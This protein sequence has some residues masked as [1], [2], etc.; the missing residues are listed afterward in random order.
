MNYRFDDLDP[1]AARRARLQAWRDLGV[2]P[3]PAI[4]PPHEQIATVRAQGNHLEIE[5]RHEGG[6]AVAGRIVAMRGQGAL[7]F[8][9]L[10]DVSGKL[11]LLFKKDIL[12]EELFERLQL[13]DTADFLWAAGTLFVSRRGELTLEVHD[14]KILAKTLSPLPDAWKGLQDVEA[15]QR[16]RYLDLLVNDGVRDRFLKRSKLI[17]SLRSFMHEKGFIEVETPVLEHIPG[18]ADAEPF[19][20]HHNALDTDFYLRISLELHLKRLV[21]GGFD[22]VFEIGKVFR[23]E[24]MSPQHLQEFTE[25][26]F[27]WA[28]ADY[29]EQMALVQEMF[30]RV[31]QDVYGTLQIERGEHM[32]NFDG[33][34]PRISYVEVVQQY[35]GINILDASDDELIQSLINH[36]VRTGGGDQQVGDADAFR[37]LGRGRMIDLLYKKTTR[38][39]LI[40]PQFLVDFPLE[41]S[42]LAKKKASDPRVTERFATLIAGFEV[43]NSYSELNDP[44]DQRERFEQQEK[45]RLAGDPEAQRLDEDFLRAMEHGMP[46]MTGFGAGIDRLVA[47]LSGSE[48]VR[49]TVLFPTMRPSEKNGEN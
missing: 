12:S 14:W 49:E 27:Y 29:T 47:I 46:P 24:G 4:T 22:R 48:S 35:A 37:R 33:E 8:M 7:V 16:Q 5:G 6:S 20:T 13:L 1:F 11:Q 43:S 25:F 10:E 23:N 19:I 40:Q 44:L 15:R 34:W 9:D 3:Y 2:D 28:Y 32:L 17:A 18:G 41:F 38:P 45:L 42:P 31:V 26:E 36:G 21:A 39:H 30:Q